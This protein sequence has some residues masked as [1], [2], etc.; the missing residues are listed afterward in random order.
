MKS[1]KIERVEETGLPNQGRISALREKENYKYLKK[2]ELDKQKGT[3][4]NRPNEKRADDFVS[5]LTS[6]RWHKQIV[7]S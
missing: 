1:G 5:D 4:T 2:N 7:C 6:E 3:L